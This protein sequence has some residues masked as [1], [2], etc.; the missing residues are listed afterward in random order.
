MYGVPII[1]IGVGVAKIWFALGLS[2]ECSKGI[3]SLYVT[4]KVAG[5]HCFTHALCGPWFCGVCFW[6]HS[7]RE[8]YKK[9][10]A[11]IILASIQAL[12]GCDGTA[13]RMRGLKGVPD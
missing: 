10:E 8:L 11:I 13:R 12:H 4:C 3:V 9:S 2:K 6:R 5:R 7:M 1:I